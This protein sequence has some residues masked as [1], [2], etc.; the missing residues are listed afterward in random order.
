M[1]FSP[2]L[3]LVTRRELAVCILTI[4]LIAGCKE[5]SPS[6][7]HGTVTLDGESVEL[8]NIVFLPASGSGP[9]AAAPIEQGVYS[10][11]ASEKLVP[12]SYRVEIS[13]RKP[14]GRKS[15]SAD[16]GM[17]IDETREAVPAKYNT[18]ST[19]IVEIGRGDVAKNFDLIS[20]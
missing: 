20:R 11:P 17:M 19:L 1:P 12:G 5:T 3:L 4:C 8:G 9:R 7:I 13:W 2:Q 16:P 15:A 14:T 18:D 10:I 6:S